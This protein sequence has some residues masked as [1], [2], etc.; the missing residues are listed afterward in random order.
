MS[1]L[2]IA[3]AGHDFFAPC[4]RAI[5]EYPGVD[6]VLCLTHP[7]ADNNRYIRQLAGVANIPTIEGRLS[8]PSIELL[9]VARIDLLVSAAYFYKI[10]IDKLNVAYAVN[11]HPSLLPDGRGP[12]PLPYY[13]DEHPESC[14]VS[15][16]ELTPA[17]DRGPLLIQ[18]QIGVREG[19]SVDEL[20]LK[21][22]A[23]APRLLLTL[24]RNIESLFMRKRAQAGGSYWPE[25]TSEERTVTTY[26]VQTH[27]VMQMHR[28]FG[29][30]GLIF[31][32]QD[33]SA[34]EA[35]QVTST[36]CSHEFVPGTIVGSVETGHIVALRD[37]LLTIRA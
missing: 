13:V 27:D 24:I 5:L 16:H 21:I 6:V 31:Q 33:G 11:V 26:E 35:T 23:V 2:R 18:E 36:Q 1:N 8:D 12:N 17:M 34:L 7:A 9:N 22:V 32:L 30:F 28:K 37:G 10:P 3:Y 29:M 14:G 4:L 20:Y 19:E 25:Y 15:I